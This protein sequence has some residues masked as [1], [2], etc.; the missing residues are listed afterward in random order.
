MA[1][2]REHE[3]VGQKGVDADVVFCINAVG[4]PFL[5][6][7]LSGCLFAI[8]DLCRRAAAASTAA[9]ARQAETI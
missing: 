2:D 6:M 4:W 3:N 1:D 7:Q 9:S 5:A 8:L